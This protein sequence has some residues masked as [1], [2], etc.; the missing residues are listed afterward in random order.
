MPSTPSNTVSSKE[1]TTAH[2]GIVNLSA[3]TGT[4]EDQRRAFL[5]ILASSPLASASGKVGAHHNTG[6]DTGAR[7]ADLMDEAIDILKN[8]DFSKSGMQSRH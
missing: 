3:A 1:Q 2:Q 5:Q 8:S 4:A 7:L 6:R